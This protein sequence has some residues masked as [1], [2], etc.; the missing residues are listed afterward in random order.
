M[1]PV[2]FN[3]SVSTSTSSNTQSPDNVTVR[4]GQTLQQVADENHVD[5]NDLMGANG[6]TNPNAVLPGQEL[7]LPTKSYARPSISLAGNNQSAPQTSSAPR[8]GSVD[9]RMMG[10]MRMREATSNTIID[11]AGKAGFSYMELARLGATLGSLSPSEFNK[12]SAKIQ[13]S[14]NSGDKTGALRNMGLANAAHDIV[15][16][17]GG[18]EAIQAQMTQKPGEVKFD[19]ERPVSKD[20]ASKLIFQGGKVP[21]GAQLEQ[22]PGNSWLVKFGGD[23]D[24]QQNVASHLNSHAETSDNMQP[25]VTFTWAMGAPHDLPPAS[26][27]KD[28]DNDYGFKVTKNYPLDQGQVRTDQLKSIAGK[29]FGYELQFD[30]PMTKDE[31][32]EKLFTNGAKF[33]PAD[34]KL[35][36]V[37]SEPSNT[38]EVRMVGPDALTAIKGKYMPAFADSVIYNKESLP[39]NLPAGLQ[40]QFKNHTIP[41][42]AKK[43]PP[44]TYMWEKDGYIAYV[45]SDGKDFYEAQ[46]TKM[47]DDP[48]LKKTIQYFME[49]K[50]MPPREAWQAFDKHWDELD[51]MMIMAMMNFYAAAGGSVGGAPEAEVGSTMREARLGRAGEGAE[52]EVGGEA[53]GA[54]SEIGLAKTEKQDL[55]VANTEKQNIGLAKTDKQDIAHA[56]TEKPNVGN[57]PTGK[58]NHDVGDGNRTPVSQGDARKIQDAK[59]MQK[60]YDNLGDMHPMGRPDPKGGEPVSVDTVL[61]A[62]DKG[63]PVGESSSSKFHKQAYRDA[64]GKTGDLEAPVAYKVG[65]GYRVDYTRLTPEQKARINAIRARQGR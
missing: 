50:G 51:R 21:D 7:H 40:D 45:K 2:N 39:P 36:A 4:V 55:G 35:E 19:F 31:V 1:P 28:I 6:I 24:S 3:A 64:T 42:D 65:D 30:K 44:D 58:Q 27:R 43:F 8:G 61:D 5:L 18:G 11:Q 52:G 37:P 54:D 53:R 63:A 32:M 15:Q 62:M 26:H 13:N 20:V 22:G 41:Q 23:L 60:K 47:P 49:Q 12:W 10:E 59:D 33:N 46:A 14:L 9:A 16:K 56:N 17:Q 29:G 48:A 57:A 25:G 34:V 38:Y